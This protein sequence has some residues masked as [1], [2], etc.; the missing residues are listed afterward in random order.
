MTVKTILAITVFLLVEKRIVTCLKNFN[1]HSMLTRR[2]ECSSIRAEQ[3]AV[4][5]W[6][7]KRWTCNQK[8]VFHSVLDSF[9]VHVFGMPVCSTS[10]ILCACVPVSLVVSIAFCMRTF[11]DGIVCVAFFPLSINVTKLGLM[12]GTHGLS[13]QTVNV[14]YKHC[15]PLRAQCI[16]WMGSVANSWQREWNGFIGDHEHVEIGSIQHSLFGIICAVAIYAWWWSDSECGLRLCREE[17][18][19]EQKN[20]HRFFIISRYIELP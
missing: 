3:C 4:C 6:Y 18:E 5:H 2:V 11:F 9:L 16:A 7:N 12:K 13:L 20:V 19:R 17:S 1:P 14:L 8:P 10:D 15:T